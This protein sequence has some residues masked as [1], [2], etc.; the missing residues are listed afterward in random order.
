MKIQSL[1]YSKQLSTNIY[2]SNS[3]NDQLCEYLNDNNLLP[4]CQSGFRSLHSMLTALIEATNC[5]S[6]NIDK[7]RFIFYEHGGGGG[8]EDGVGGHE[9]KK[10][11]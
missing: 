8:G 4:H 7:G 1:G 5:C 11:H 2:Y 3:C 10:W 9:K 6:T